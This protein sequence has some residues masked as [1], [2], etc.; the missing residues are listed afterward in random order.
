[1]RDAVASDVHRTDLQD[2]QSNGGTAMT[3]STRIQ[4]LK[5]HRFLYMLYVIFHVR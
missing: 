2:Q 4:N 1:M 3:V 5:P